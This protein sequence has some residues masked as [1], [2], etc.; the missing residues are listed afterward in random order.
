M[1]FFANTYTVDKM[2]REA[3]CELKV[4]IAHFQAESGTRTRFIEEG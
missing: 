3:I 4:I 1:P 2:Y